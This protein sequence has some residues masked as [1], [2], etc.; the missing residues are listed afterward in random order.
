[1]HHNGLQNMFIACGFIG[2][3]INLLCLPMVFWGK[4]ARRALAKRYYRMVKE[5]GHL[6]AP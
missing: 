3:C 5:Q 2:L 4:A 1:M 6:L